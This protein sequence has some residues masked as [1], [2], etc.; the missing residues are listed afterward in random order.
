[1]NEQDSTRLVQRFY[2]NI[3]RKDFESALMLM[4]PDVEW[5]VPQMDG[6]SFSGT[7]HGRD[8]VEAFFRK[9]RETQ[10]QVEFHVDEFIGQRDKVVVL[11]RFVMLV[12]ATGRTS[13]SR[14]AHVWTLRNGE[15]SHLREFVDTATVISAHREGSW[16][17]RT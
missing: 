15:I 1:M 12:R 9:V 14:W 16:S 4:A 7:W 6:V 11:G 13:A 10:E 17:S 5:C 2:E 8:G 3:G